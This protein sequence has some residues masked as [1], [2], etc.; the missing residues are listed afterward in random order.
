MVSWF[1]T[2]IPALGV[3]VFWGGGAWFPPAHP[4]PLTGQRAVTLALC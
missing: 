3:Q 1:L 4:L 2:V